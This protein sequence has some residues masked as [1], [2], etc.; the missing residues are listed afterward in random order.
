MKTRLTMR[1]SRFA[2]LGQLQHDVVQVHELALVA[3]YAAPKV[4]IPHLLNCPDPPRR[5]GDE[6]ANVLDIASHDRETYPAGT[7]EYNDDVAY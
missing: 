5:A 3:A 6:M 4:F 7:A 2:E 1:I